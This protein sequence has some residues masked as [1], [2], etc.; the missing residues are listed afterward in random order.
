[1][2][3]Q[4]KPL[5]EE[6]IKLLDEALARQTSKEELKQKLKK[7]EKSILIKYTKKL[8]M[9]NVGEANSQEQILDAICEFLVTE[10]GKRMAAHSLTEATY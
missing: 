6:M 3:K 10:K 4:K 1:M 8:E 7:N 9:N 2:Q 5:S